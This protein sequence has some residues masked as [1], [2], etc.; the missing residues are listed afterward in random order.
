MGLDAM[1]GDGLNLG[2]EKIHCER[3]DGTRTLQ[4]ISSASKQGDEIGVNGVQ[5]STV[6][7]A[8]DHP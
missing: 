4:S 5:V 2:G 6:A 3:V 1:G 7:V 8:L